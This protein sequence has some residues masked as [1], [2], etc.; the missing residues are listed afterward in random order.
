[1]CT[2][3]LWLPLA[4]I[5]ELAHLED[6]PKVYF[7]FSRKWISKNAKYFSDGKDEDRFA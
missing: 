1:M 5:M 4:K 7:L 2:D 6:L 3:E